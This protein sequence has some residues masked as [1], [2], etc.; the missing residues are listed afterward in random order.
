MPTQD[1]K[2]IIVVAKLTDVVYDLLQSIATGT[3]VA[4]NLLN[5]LDKVVKCVDIVDYGY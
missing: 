2:Q 3:R 1:V 5:E 4:L